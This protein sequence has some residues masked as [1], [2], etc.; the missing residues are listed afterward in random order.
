HLAEARLAALEGGL[1]A[2][3]VV[4]EQAAV[5]Q[6]RLVRR[7]VVAVQLAPRQR[8]DVLQAQVL[9]PEVGALGQPQRERELAVAALAVDDGGA[10]RSAARRGATA[11]SAAC[12]G[13][14]AA[15]G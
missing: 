1:A 12:C 9:A 4:H 8:E 2:E 6:R 5:V 14:C 7:G 11:G 15:A 3:V 10:G 13:R